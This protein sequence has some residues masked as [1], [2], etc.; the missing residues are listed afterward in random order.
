MEQN[1]LTRGRLPDVKGDGEEP[2]KSQTESQ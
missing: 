1:D 2:T